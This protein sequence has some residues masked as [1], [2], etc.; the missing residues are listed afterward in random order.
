[1]GFTG[2]NDCPLCYTNSYAFNIMVQ[3]D[4]GGPWVYLNDNFGIPEIYM[5]N[6]AYT[7][8]AY[9]NKESRK[10]IMFDPPFQATSIKVMYL[11]NAD[12]KTSVNLDGS[13]INDCW[14]HIAMDF[15]IF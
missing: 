14:S 15:K 7:D 10:T 8:T 13:F 9:Y 5:G 3:T 12:G 11:V 2:R 6:F 4:S 1:M